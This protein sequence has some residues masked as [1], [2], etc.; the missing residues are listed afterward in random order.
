MDGDT[1]FAISTNDV[2]NKEILQNTDILALGAR[3]SDCLARACN[4]A[5]FEANIIG[6]SKPA[7]KNLFK[8][9]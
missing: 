2:S 3:A 7:W 5:V 4:R 6:K 9:K 8:G 1:I